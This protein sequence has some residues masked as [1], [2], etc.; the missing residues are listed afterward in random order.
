M[1]II[2]LYFK[3]RLWVLRRDQPL[4]HE[5]VDSSLLLNIFLI[6]IQ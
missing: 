6:M 5:Y 4:I 1:S 3:V 2:F